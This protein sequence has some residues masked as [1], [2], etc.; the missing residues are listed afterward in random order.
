MGKISALCIANFKPPSCCANQPA[1]SRLTA[2]Q[3]KRIRETTK[4]VKRIITS[5]YKLMADM[6][7]CD[8]LELFSTEI[9]ECLS[10]LPTAFSTLVIYKTHDIL[11]NFINILL[12]RKDEQLNKIRMNI[13]GNH[14][15]SG[16]AFPAEFKVCSRKAQE[17]LEQLPTKKTVDAKFMCLKETV[18]ML[19]QTE[20]PTEIHADILLI[21]FAHLITNSSITNWN[22]Q[23]YFMKTF[24]FSKHLNLGEESY[25]L[26][27]VEAAILHL[28]S[29]SIPIPIPHTSFKNDDGD[30]FELS[31][32]GDVANIEELLYATRFKCHPLCTCH[33]C[34]I[35]LLVNG[36]DYDSNGFTA[37]HYACIN[38]HTDVTQLLLR[39]IFKNK[40]EAQDPIHG[41]T[42]LHWAAC[43]GFQ[44]CLLL[45]CH[46]N[47]DLNVADK[48]GNNALHLA[49]RNGHESCVK[50]LLYF[51]EHAHIRLDVN[52]RNLCGEGALHLAAKLGYAS[53]ASLLME[54]NAD[55]HL[56]NLK[57][58]TA[59]AVAQN[60]LLAQYILHSNE[61]VHKETQS[62]ET[63]SVSSSKMWLDL[64]K[65]LS[66]W[67]V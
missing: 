60:S 57:K 3:Q 14:I 4:S 6:M 31:R 24:L 36:S 28:K 7:E 11:F 38:G 27:T 21:L 56:L 51:A 34:G 15:V 16:L 64:K 41:R 52:S 42:A 35:P 39:T 43:Q 19:T 48:D 5:H 59:V 45:L 8:Q 55:K 26:S 33:S 67:P 17:I 63:Q 37:L 9:K 61:P 47:C 20:V 23:L 30:I 13:S 49:V 10:K 25:Y 2:S 65:Q 58:Q 54:W 29:T 18:E 1:T 12:S 53:I 40:T 62:K 50:A 46:Q 44:T 66:W 22:A 32:K